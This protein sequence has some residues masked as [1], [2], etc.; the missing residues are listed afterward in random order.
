MVYTVPKL[1]YK[2]H[3][4]VVDIPK[5]LTKLQEKVLQEQMLWH[6]SL[7][8]MALVSLF[9]GY[10]IVTVYFRW[11]DA[12]SHFGRLTSLS[13]L[14][15]LKLHWIVLASSF[16][17][18]PVAPLIHCEWIDPTTQKYWMAYK[19]NILGILGSVQFVDIYE[20]WL[21][22][23]CGNLTFWRKLCVLRQNEAFLI[24]NKSKTNNNFE[25]KIAI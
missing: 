13:I 7:P 14:G 12:V 4:T 15:S 24:K 20:V 10:C 5:I 18:P 16:C 2:N 21:E 22:S 11:P 23:L 25:G 9:W 6:P 8:R 17:L 19:H 1:K 3:C